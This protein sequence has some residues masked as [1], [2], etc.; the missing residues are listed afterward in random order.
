MQ[1][2]GRMVECMFCIYCSKCNH[3]KKTMIEA[4][5]CDCLEHPYN[6]DTDRPIYFE[7]KELSDVK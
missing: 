5:C 3:S 7:S 2:E 1:G 4:P 6:V